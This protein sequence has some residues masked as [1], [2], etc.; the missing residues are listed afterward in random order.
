MAAAGGAAG[1]ACRRQ[2]GFEAVAISYLVAGRE[3]G[4]RPPKAANTGQPG[5]T[6]S[7]SGAVVAGADQQAG[8]QVARRALGSL[9]RWRPVLDS[10][11]GN[12]VFGGW[13]PVHAPAGGALRRARKWGNPPVRG[14]R[15]S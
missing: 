4:D 5:R 6:R 11:N 14:L 12:A 10:F 8:W 2:L 1:R 13:W 9:S 3:A 15:Q 7:G